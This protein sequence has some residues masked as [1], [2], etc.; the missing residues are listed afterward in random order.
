MTGEPSL[1]FEPEVGETD[2]NGTSQTFGHCSLCRVAL[3]DPV[4]AAEATSILRF[5]VQPE[6][7]SAIVI[8]TV[9]NAVCT[10]GSRENG[11]NR[12]SLKLYADVPQGTQYGRGFFD[13]IE[14]RFE[15]K[16]WVDSVNRRVKASA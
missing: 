5:T 15:T 10:L 14:Y 9:S 7:T 2:W 12:S 4:A 16:W 8:Q 13:K 11:E 1:G 3:V 6:R